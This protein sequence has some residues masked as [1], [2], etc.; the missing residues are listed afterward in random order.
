MHCAVDACL[1][2]PSSD[3]SVE[4]NDFA[5][6]KL[7][8]SHALRFYQQFRAAEFSIFSEFLYELIAFD[9]AGDRLHV[10][11]G[12][13]SLTTAANASGID[14]IFATNSHLAAAIACR[15][16][17]PWWSIQ[18]P[19]QRLVQN[20]QSRRAVFPPA[21]VSS[22]AR[23]RYDLA[24]EVEHVGPPCGAVVV[25]LCLDLRLRL[26]PLVAGLQ[27]N[28][29]S[30]LTTSARVRLR[31]LCDVMAKN[32]SYGRCTSFIVM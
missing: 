28:S 16:S 32:A 31:G 17:I 13:R 25:D 30:R 24:Q 29:N 19:G 6:L 26:E 8:P 10:Q 22:A 27:S 9:A 14:D 11:L 18:A 5:F 1:T 15:P 3:I 2:A 23:V 21:R 12:T 20:A 7:K 4:P